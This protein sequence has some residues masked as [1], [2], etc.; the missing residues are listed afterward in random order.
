MQNTVRL[1]NFLFYH[2]FL[3]EV[4]DLNRSRFSFVT[5]VILANASLDVALHD[6]VA[7]IISN[8]KKN[9]DNMTHLAFNHSLLVSNIST[10]YNLVSY[11]MC[12]G[13]ITVPMVKD[14]KL[15]AFV[16]GLIDGDGSF[17]VN[18]WQRKSLQYRLVVKLKN[19][20][21]NLRML[22]HIASVYGGQVYIVT[23]L[24]TA[25]QFV[26]WTINDKKVIQSSILPLFAAYPPLTTRVTLQIAFL[27]KALD[28]MTMEE[29]FEQ[30]KSKY[31]TRSSITP[32]FETVP[33]Y[34]SSWLSGFIEAEGSFATRS[35]NLGFS[36]SISQLNDHY[37]M[38]A[39]LKTFYQE[40]LTV[41]VKSQL[42]K[43]FYFIE[44]ANM[45][46][47]EVVVRHLMEYPLQGY[48]YHQLAKV[49]KV[50]KTLS[51]LRNVFWE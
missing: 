35:G 43:P 14:E 47:V 48:K 10:E 20:P 19:E 49:I 42:T 36:F 46:G 1:N 30:R 41:Q 34:F 12:C 18:H 28:G 5:G 45:R 9:V 22:T 4:S 44:I 21:L 8:L 32:L 2:F 26:T 39:I 15:A 24:K 50:S 37:L 6:T 25:S 16:V 33:P 23:V 29:Y 7:L 31:S 51:H 38:N 40:H 11:G 3:I 27:I 13:L 17:Q